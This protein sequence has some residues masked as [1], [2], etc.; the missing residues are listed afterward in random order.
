MV[1]PTLPPPHHKATKHHH[2]L[3]RTVGNMA[4]PAQG[5]YTERTDSQYA[6]FHLQLL[7]INTQARH[8]FKHTKPFCRRLH[9][10]FGKAFHIGQFPF[11]TSNHQ[12][13]LVQ[14]ITDYKV[15]SRVYIS[16]M[17]NSHLIFA[18][19]YFHQHSLGGTFTVHT[20]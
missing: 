19:I 8:T 11:L 2:P 1:K 16:S 7:L 9:K 10:R 18:V 5:C 6:T 20:I 17:D 15:L 12:I 3:Y 13:G 14:N 4:I